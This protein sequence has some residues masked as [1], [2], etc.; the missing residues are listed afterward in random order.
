VPAPKLWS[1]QLGG[2]M[3]FVPS[4]RLHLTYPESEMNGR[5]TAEVYGG[6]FNELFCQLLAS[7]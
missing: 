4:A 3:C 1:V 2:F 6:Y 7:R 5:R